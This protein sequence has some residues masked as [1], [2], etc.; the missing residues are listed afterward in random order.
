MCGVYFFDKITLQKKIP[1]LAEN[2]ENTYHYKQFCMKYK[3]ILQAI[4]Q[5]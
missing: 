1:D 5:N 3:R 2:T 4:L